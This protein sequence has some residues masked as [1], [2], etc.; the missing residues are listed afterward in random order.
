MGVEL[1]PNQATAVRT[2]RNGSILKG[3]VGSGKSRTA[4]A[5]FVLRVCEGQIPINGIG[6]VRPMVRPRD[7][8]IITTA[9]KR[10]KLE[11]E[12]EASDFALSPDRDASFGGVQVRVDSWNNIGRYTDVRDAF[13]VFDEQ[14]LVGS[15]A[16]VKSFY[17]IVN[18]NRWILLSA[19]PGDTWMDYIPVFVAH[20]FFKN[21]TEFIQKHVVYNT[22][23][24]FPQIDHFVDTKVLEDYKREITVDM[25]YSRHTIR[26]TE[27]IMVF[28]DEKQFARVQKDRWHIYED[29]PLND[30]GEMFLV[31]RKLVNTD[32]SRVAAV[33]ELMEKHPKL[34]IF[35]NFNSELEMLRQFQDMLDVPVA[36][37]NGHRH[38]EIP[39]TDRWL[40]L[41]QYTAGAEGWNCISTD[42]MVFWSLNYSYKIF[43]QAKGRIDRLNTPY[44]DLYYY[45]LRSASAVDTAITKALATKQAFNEKDYDSWFSNPNP[46]G[47]K[48]KQQSELLPSH[49]YGHN[50]QRR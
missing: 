22:F 21:R 7:L 42:A 12:A 16:W 6:D 39:D 14:R 45:V 47:L 40:Y 30:V 5:Y 8:Y 33:M 3:D 29:R 23:R 11:W 43:E 24:K 37:W 34:I 35:Y 18:R 13:F 1:A 50:T 44:T 15:G 48:M 27:N 20:G 46:S 49:A 28:Y 17:K 2:L 41:V 31:M 38:Q 36:E 25:P 10:D 4:L 32:V 26:H 19:T 9:K